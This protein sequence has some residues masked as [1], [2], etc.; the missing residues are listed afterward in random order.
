MRLHPA[1]VP[2]VHDDESPA[3]AC[4]RAAMLSGRSAR[5]LCLDM[6]I[7]FQRVVDGDADA[8]AT[9]A[10]ALRHEDGNLPGLP[11]VGSGRRFAIAGQ[12][13]TRETLSRKVLRVCPRCVAAD[14]ANGA[15]PREAR[16]YARTLWSVASLRTCPVHRCQL[17]VA[18]TDGRPQALHDFSRLIEPELERILEEPALEM[19]G[20]PS[21]LEAHLMA[22]LSGRQV[23]GWLAQFPAYAACRI[24]EIVGAV[25]EQGIRFRTSALGEPEWHRAGATGFAIVDAGPASIKKFLNGLAVTFTS[26]KADWGPRAMY[27]RLYEWLAHESEDAAYDPLRHVIRGHVIATLP[28]G[29]GDELF[30]APVTERLIHSI[31]S[32]AAEIG[33]HP[34]TV[35]KL[36]LANNTIG[37]SS[38]GVSDHRV[39]MR[40]EAARGA[41]LMSEGYL[42]FGEM[43]SRLGAPRPHDKMLVDAGFIPRII[44][45]KHMGGLRPVYDAADVSVF[46]ECLTEDALPL[47]K[48]RKDLVN[49]PKAAKRAK[50]SAMA[51]VRLL[52]DRRLPTVRLL[53]GDVGYMSVLVDPAEVRPLVQEER[54]PGLTL[55]QV[56]EILRTSDAVTRKLV[57]LG[58]LPSTSVMNPMTRMTQHVVDPADLDAFRQRY[59]AGPEIARASGGNP[60]SVIQKAERRG[61]PPVFDPREV[62]VAFYERAGVPYRWWSTARWWPNA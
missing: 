46:L 59:V 27:G 15:G 40:A 1:L 39:L 53:P 4:S 22:R 17:V 31:H 42:T 61:I 52:L 21:G 43:V 8:L 41:L 60:M 36:L 9:L 32:Y 49:I 50:C 12:E 24:A 2:V 13:F 47:E 25:A 45:G 44:R 3:S 51:I 37:P 58:H 6:G 30:G 5:D 7:E 34:K 35:R 54:A 18:S 55:R 56:T 23:E 29:P 26:G 14:V 48:N 28:V 11:V 19:E 20:P 38:D 10:S 16:P 62:G 33:R 57:E